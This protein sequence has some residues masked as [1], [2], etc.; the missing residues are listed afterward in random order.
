MNK[1]KS[2]RSFPR[3]VTTQRI[4]LKS[5]ITTFLNTGWTECGGKFPIN[6]RHLLP[7]DRF[8]DHVQKESNEFG[9]G[10]RIYTSLSR[11]QMTIYLKK[12][13]S[14]TYI[15]HHG[16]SPGN[17]INTDS[18]LYMEQVRVVFPLSILHFL[19][20]PPVSM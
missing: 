11:Q 13:P 16:R 15:D 2:T 8:F 6:R 5:F 4:G 12:R 1:A 9:Y 14:I 7:H 20:N 18:Y 10:A 17:S 19:S 3:Y